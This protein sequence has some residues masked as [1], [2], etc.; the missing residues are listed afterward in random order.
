MTF[1]IFQQRDEALYLCDIVLDTKF[2][3]QYKSLQLPKFQ[4]YTWHHHVRISDGLHLVY[5]IVLY[6]GV[7][8]SVEII[9][10]VNNLHGR[11]LSRD[12]G[13]ADN[14]TEVDCDGREGFCCNSLLK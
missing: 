4:L 14:V 5:I 6:D 2:D 11:A 13:E 1:L 10:K 7:E 3:T 8:A 12:G 9:K